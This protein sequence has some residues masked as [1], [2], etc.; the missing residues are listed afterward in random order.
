MTGALTSLLTALTIPLV[1][2]LLAW[3]YPAPQ[4]RAEGASLEELWPKYRKW[5]FIALVAYMALWFPVSAAIYWPL[6]VI[7]RWRAEA[8]QDSANTFVFFVDG[9]ALWIPSFFMALLLAGVLL[10]PA[11]KFLL[12]ERYAEYERY[13]ALRFG[14]DQNRVMKGFGIVITSA[15]VVAVL[16]LF[17]A[18]FVASETELRVNPLL[19][20]ERRYVYADVSEIMTAPAL[21]APNGNTVHRRVYLL[22]F[23]DGTS[24]TTDDMP[25]YE[26]GS[27]SRTLLIQSIVQRSGISPKE[28]AVFERG[29]L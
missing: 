2:W 13:A 21:V 8:M 29:E 26:L 10:T 17:D 12:K 27:R 25:E 23:N 15:F 18:Y 4:L 5:E 9:A 22:R 1:F 16:A 20:L 19:G 24:Y 3:K 28:K 14:F 6:H 11:I 7:V